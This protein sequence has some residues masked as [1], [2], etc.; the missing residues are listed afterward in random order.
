MT[1][2]DLDLEKSAKAIK[3]HAKKSEKDFQIPITVFFDVE[4]RIFNTKIFDD[5]D[6]GEEIQENHHLLSEDFFKDLSLPVG[7]DTEIINSF[8]INSLQENENSLK[9][10]LKLDGRLKDYHLHLHMLHVSDYENYEKKSAELV[11]LQLMDNADNESINK[12]QSEIKEIVRAGKKT[13]ADI[14]A[15]DNL[16]DI[17]REKINVFKSTIEQ[18]H[19]DI[20]ASRLKR[21]RTEKGLTQGKLAQLA[22]TSQ[23][24]ITSY[25]IAKREPTLTTLFRLSQVLG[26]SV[27]WLLG[28]ED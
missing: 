6:I 20:F 2:F 16:M 13:N 17:V 22:I 28:L 25:E 15:T 19:R 12:T 8:F 3:E 26:R 1:E 24:A 27:D 5:I 14:R 7:N 10:F 4:R 9:K 11:T 23:S 21:A 18:Q